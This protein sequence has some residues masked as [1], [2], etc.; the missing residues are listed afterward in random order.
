[1]SKEGKQSQEEKFL[2]GEG[3]KNMD[4]RQ[5]DTKS[6]KQVRIDIGWHQLL[7][8]EATKAGITIKELLDDILSGWFDIK[9]YNGQN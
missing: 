1:M 3:K 9:K 5:S 4:N 2:R 7:K 8:L 6:T